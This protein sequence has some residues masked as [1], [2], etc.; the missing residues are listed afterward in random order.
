MTTFVLS[1]SP[2]EKS[3]RQIELMICAFL[4]Q[5][6]LPMSLSESVFELTKRLFSGYEALQKVYL[7]KQRTSNIIR[8]V[9]GP[10]FSE[11]LCVILRERPFSVILDEAADRSTSKQLSFIAQY[12]DDN[13]VCTFLDLLEVHSATAEGILQQS[14]SA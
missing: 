2:T 6:Y 10:W 9:F 1:N 4:A 3:A 8:Q 7:G 5:H 11:E 13:L 12:F 14:K